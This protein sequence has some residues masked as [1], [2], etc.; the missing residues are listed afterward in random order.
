MQKKK[1]LL[2]TILSIMI[3]STS[4][5]GCSKADTSKKNTPKIATQSSDNSTKND[6]LNQDSFKE[7]AVETFAPGTA[8]TAADGGGLIL[9]HISDKEIDIGD[10]SKYIIIAK[11]FVDIDEKTNLKKELN[12]EKPDFYLI[13]RKECLLNEINDPIIFNNGEENDGNANVQT[14]LNQ[15]FSNLD[16][17]N[18]FIKYI[19]GHTA[20]DN[21]GM[22]GFANEEE[23]SLFF[24]EAEELSKKGNE[25]KLAEKLD[26][27]EKTFKTEKESLIYN[28]KKNYRGADDNFIG[29]GF[30]IP[31]DEE[32]PSPM[33]LSFQEASSFLSDLYDFSFYNDVGQVKLYESGIFEMFESAYAQIHDEVK[34]EDEVFSSNP[35]KNFERLKDKNVSFWLRSPGDPILTFEKFK[36]FPYLYS[37]TAVL[38]SNE[39]KALFDM[40]K[41]LKKVTKEVDEDAS[42]VSDDDSSSSSSPDSSSSTSFIVPYSNRSASTFCAINQFFNLFAKINFFP[43]TATVIGGESLYVED[44]DKDINRASK[45]GGLVTIWFDP[46]D[47]KTGGILEDVPQDNMRALRLRPAFWVKADI[48]NEFKEENKAEEKQEEKKE[49]KKE[50]KKQQKS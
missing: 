22:Y 30:S 38:A 41:L 31:D 19:V 15:W 50:Q 18:N 20:N 35:K 4:V 29:T 5:T 2:A 13:V 24:E 8:G 46:N 49:E 48:M 45:D 43:P 44:A 37:K 14:L 11:H 9:S 39:V 33:I 40:F 34:N 25:E 27:I 17:N 36:G 1:K 26:V 16:P 47:F 3:L 7:E 21:L 42:E 32:N 10:G 28:F 6:S 23:V 12:E